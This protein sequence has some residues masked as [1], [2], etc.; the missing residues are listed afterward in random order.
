MTETTPTEVAVVEQKP[1][2][3]RNPRVIKNVAIA[4]AGAA[5]AV[6][7]IAKFRKNEDDADDTT[8][9]IVID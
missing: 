7:V 9:E 6:L 8:D 2:F 3:Y 5:A 4:T 1:P